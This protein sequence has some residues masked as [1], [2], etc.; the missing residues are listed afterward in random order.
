MTALGD[1]RELQTDMAEAAW[2]L[3]NAMD[4]HELNERKFDDAIHAKNKAM[5]DED[6]AG[7]R[8][9]FKFRLFN[10]SDNAKLYGDKFC[11][12]CNRGL[13]CKKHPPP[14]LQKKIETHLKEEQFHGN[15]EVEKV[16][17]LGQLR[18]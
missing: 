8:T 15:M 17:R 6:E 12:A 5:K 11:W 9:R 16:A 18:V 1:N 7:K 13:E 2:D 14:D 4:A 3:E 10:I